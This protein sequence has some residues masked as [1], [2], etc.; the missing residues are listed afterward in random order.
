MSV[1]RNLNTVRVVSYFEGLSLYKGAEWGAQTLSLRPTEIR[2]QAFGKV[3][4]KQQVYDKLKK[5]YKLLP[6]DE[7]GNDESDAIAAALAGWNYIN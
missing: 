7:G 6:Y 4:S 5:R 1:S 3:I 2:Q